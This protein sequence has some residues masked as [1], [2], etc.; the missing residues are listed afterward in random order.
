MEQTDQ[1]IPLLQWIWDLYD[2][3]AV[4]DVYNRSTIVD[5]KLAAGGSTKL[6]DFRLARLVDYGADPRTTQVVMGTTGYID[7]ASSLT[8]TALV[9]SSWR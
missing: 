7:Q 1:V 2:R 4:T 6:E 9:S 8:S 5:T 3:D